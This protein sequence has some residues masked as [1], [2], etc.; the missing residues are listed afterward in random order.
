VNELIKTTSEIETGNESSTDLVPQAKRFTIGGNSNGTS[1]RTY[2]NAPYSRLV[3][4]F[5]PPTESDG[6]KVSTEWV[7]TFENETMT[8]YDY[9]ETSLYASELL[10]VTEFRALPEYSWHVG[11]RNQEK[12]ERFAEYI[13]SLL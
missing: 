12:A 7:F 9:K 2:L 3:E 6:Y 11:G 13:R 1:L 8:V 5:G 4:L 10:S